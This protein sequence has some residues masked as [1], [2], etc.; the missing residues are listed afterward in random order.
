MQIDNKEAINIANNTTYLNKDIKYIKNAEITEWDIHSAGL[1]VLKFKKLLPEK[2]LE[3]L[4]NMEKHERTVREGYL[5]KENKNLSK[6]IIDTLS[7]IRKAFV[8]LNNIPANAILSIKKDALFLINLVP[9]ITTIENYFVFR[10]KGTYTSYLN[11]NNNEFYYSSRTNELISKG[12][13]KEALAKQ[14]EYLIKDIK[15]FLRSGEKV[16]EDI[17][18]SM[19]KSYREKYLERKLPIETY[20][21]LTTGYFRI[22]NYYFENADITML[23][24]IDITQNYMNYILPLFIEML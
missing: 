21:E 15:S 24:D 13:E 20:R 16:K 11:L 2:E 10:N 17:L 3:K 22:N 1:S 18:F 12:F 23:N 7:D 5:Q 14:E 8:T 19:F 4:S 6:E 9:T